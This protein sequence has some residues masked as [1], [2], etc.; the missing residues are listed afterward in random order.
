[1]R[2]SEMA[3]AV[4]G[5]AVAFLGS[6]DMATASVSAGGDTVTGNEWVRIAVV[7]LAAAA[8]V[9]LVPN[10]Q[11]KPKLSIGSVQVDVKPKPEPPP[12]GATEPHAGPY[13]YEGSRRFPG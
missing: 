9:W 12:A 3:K 11:P 13:G 5:G 7:T 2:L 1:M 4:A 6:F 8:A 10:E